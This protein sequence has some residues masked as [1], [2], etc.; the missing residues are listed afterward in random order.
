VCTVACDDADGDAMCVAQARG[1]MCSPAR[2]G[3][4]TCA[5]LGRVCDV[6]CARDRDCA[7][8]GGAFACQDG[9]CRAGGAGEG[10]SGAGEAGA[11][12]APAG[13]TGGG[14]GAGG[15]PMPGSDAGG[16]AL[17]GGA[18]PDAGSICNLPLQPGPCEAAIPR[19]Y[20][21]PDERRCLDF[22]Y[23]GCQGND[24]NFQTQAECEAACSVMRPLPGP[25]SCEVGGVVYP[26]GSDGIDDPGSCNTCSCSKGQLV[27]TD[28]ACPEPCPEGTTYG[29][30]CLQCGLAGGCSMSSTGCLPGCDDDLDCSQNGSACLD[31]LC[32]MLCL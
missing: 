25:G 2:G 30:V 5:G 14:A 9:R 19:F 24:N 20:Y 11:G 10:G 32:Q 28:I 7:A 26:D 21:A 1:A 27:C 16:V 18:A 3:D 23:G 31:G 17:D 15:E 29:T 13:G 6:E 12:G 4:A 8:L 22:I